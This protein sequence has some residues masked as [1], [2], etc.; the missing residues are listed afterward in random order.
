MVSQPSG[1]GFRVLILGMITKLLMWMVYYE[2]NKSCFEFDVLQLREIC[3]HKQE[4]VFES[5]ALTDN[6]CPVAARALCL[7]TESCRQAVELH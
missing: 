4:R 3:K 2:S 5:G 1:G 7:S 6:A